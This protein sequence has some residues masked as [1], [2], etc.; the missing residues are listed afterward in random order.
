MSQIAWWVYYR[1]PDFM[2]YPIME[3]RGRKKARYYNYKVD[4]FNRNVGK[5]VF[6]KIPEAVYKIRR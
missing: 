1:M 4:R 5:V 3:R 2:F 6:Q